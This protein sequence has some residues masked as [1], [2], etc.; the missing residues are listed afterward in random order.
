M[1]IGPKDRSAYLLYGMKQMMMIVP[2][3]A[4]VDKAE[5][6]AH[7]YRKQGVQRG[8]I[9]SVRHFHFQHHD[10]DDDGDHAIAEGFQPILFH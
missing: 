7:E 6:I 3:N 9:I 4:D 1:E 8:R 10:G 2:V 5:H